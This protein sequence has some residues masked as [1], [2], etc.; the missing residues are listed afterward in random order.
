[1]SFSCRGVVM[2]DTAIGWIVLGPAFMIAITVGFW[3]MCGVLAVSGDK[4]DS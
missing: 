2:I 1:M 3:I 4:K